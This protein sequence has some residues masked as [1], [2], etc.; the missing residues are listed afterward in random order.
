MILIIGSTHDDLLYFES[1]MTRR[2]EEK[3]LG[4]FRVVFGNVFNQEVALVEGVYS[5]YVSSMITL[6]L[7]QKYYVILVFAVGRCTALTRNWK[8]GDIA[9]SRYTV[10]GDVDLMLE[11]DT[12]L[13]QIPGCP[14]YF[15]SQEDIVSYFNT[16]AEKR[17]D[18][19][20]RLSTFVSTNSSYASRSQL[21]EMLSGDRAFGTNE[22]LI[23]EN[24]V[25][26]IAVACHFGHVPF[27]G[28]KVVSR[29]LDEPYT[30]EEY[31]TT[32][33]KYI[34][35]GKAVVSTIGDIGRSDLLGGQ[36]E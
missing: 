23:M 22:N 9:V 15:A 31:A 24:S 27:L 5:N 14:A 12:R 19:T 25:G 10:A 21:D 28:A 3:V 7:I 36:E 11:S 20:F 29:F 18:A 35:L 33:R 2:R 26:G 1:V 16:Q 6:D 32:L 13:G 17:I 30:V 34:D 4:H 8:L